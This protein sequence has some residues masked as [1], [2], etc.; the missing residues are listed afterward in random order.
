MTLYCQVSGETYWVEFSS[1]GTGTASVTKRLTY[2]SYIGPTFAQ[3]VASRINEVVVNAVGKPVG[4][5]DS[6]LFTDQTDA[7]CFEMVMITDN[8]GTM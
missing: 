3:S 4:L 2:N 8:I 1:Y 6:E 7:T 5:G